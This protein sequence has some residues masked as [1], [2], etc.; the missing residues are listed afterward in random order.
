MNDEAVAY[1]EA[2][3]YLYSFVDYSLTHNFRYT[4]DKFDLGRMFDFLRLLD[5][6]QKKYPVIHIAGTKGKGSTA[7][8]IAN[9]LMSAGYQVG[10]YTSPHLQNYTER[11]QINGQEISQAD[12]VELVSFVKPFVAKV[13]QLTTFEITTALAFLSFARRKVNVAV[14]EV[15]LGGRLDATNVVDPLVSV[16]TSLSMDHVSILGDTLPKIAFEKAG[17]IKPG[18][19]VVLAPQPEEARQVIEAVARERRSPLVEVGRDFLFAAGEHSLARQSF[20][21]WHGDLDSPAVQLTT[22]LLG[23][24]QVE[25][26]ATA[27]AALQITARHGIAIDDRAIQQGFESVFWPGRFELLRYD[28]PVVVDS[29]HNR[30]SA[31]RLR[32]ALEDYLPGRPVV[33]VFGV[34]EDKD[35]EGMLAELLPRVSRVITTQSVHPRAMDAEKLAELARQHGALPVQAVV[36]VEAA[37]AEALALAGNEAAI[38]VTGSLFIVAAVRDVWSKRLRQSKNQEVQPV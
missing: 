32:Q 17:I 16:I 26:G 13:A 15:G 27:Y 8:L 14:V 3:D 7:A 18:R 36:P 9:S 29:A 11:I 25:N 19:P 6:P 38:L 2:L 30:E 35:V 37:L 12:L 10:L 31:L 21:V 34:S 28:P 22:R 23:Q 5:D 20:K 4:P 1:Q 24:H 33:L